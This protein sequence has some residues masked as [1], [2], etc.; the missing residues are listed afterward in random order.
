MPSSFA[1][2]GETSILKTADIAP[3]R[4]NHI[5]TWLSCF[6][7]HDDRKWIGTTSAFDKE[8]RLSGFI[9][10]PVTAKRKH[11]IVPAPRKL[12]IKNRAQSYCRSGKGPYITLFMYSQKNIKSS[13]LKVRRVIL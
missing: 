12:V 6:K 8:R 5:F 3:Q 1:R 4:L 11:H 13:E 2:R 10:Q 9:K 7:Y